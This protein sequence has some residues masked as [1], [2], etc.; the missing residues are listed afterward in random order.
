MPG[1]EVVTSMKVVVSTVA[2]PSE[3]PGKQPVNFC[4]L[5]FNSK[6]PFYKPITVT[7][8]PTRGEIG[9]GS[10]SVR[11]RSKNVGP[12]TFSFVIHHMN[13][14]NNQIQDTPVT[15]NVEVVSA[16]F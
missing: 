4:S 9:H 13:P 11:Y 1:Q 3:I 7:T 16:P 6:S 12:D 10:Y 2:R 14:I 15:V 8:K 5:A